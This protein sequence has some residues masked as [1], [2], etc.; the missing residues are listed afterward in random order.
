[1]HHKAKLKHASLVQIECT[2]N[3]AT[4]VTDEYKVVECT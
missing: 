1:V 4:V 3:S 2:K